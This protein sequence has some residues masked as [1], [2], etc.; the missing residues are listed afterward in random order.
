[1]VELDDSIQVWYSFLLLVMWA[2]GVGKVRINIIY[3]IVTIGIIGIPYIYI[4]L[5][6]FLVTMIPIPHYSALGKS[7]ST[8][9]APTVRLHGISRLSVCCNDLPFPRPSQIILRTHPPRLCRCFF[10]S[11]DI[12]CLFSVAVPSPKPLS[13]ACPLQ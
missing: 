11:L 7:G 12:L 3:G 8:F 9:A 4:T 13:F 5:R 10:F 2:G 1:M 6:R